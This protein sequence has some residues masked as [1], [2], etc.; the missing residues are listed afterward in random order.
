MVTT[1]R[2]VINREYKTFKL[3]CYN[4]MRIVFCRVHSDP[5]YYKP[6]GSWD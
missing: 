1:R 3:L 6:R 5:P 2:N 4:V